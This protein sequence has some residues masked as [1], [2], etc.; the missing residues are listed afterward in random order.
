M[1]T[2][3]TAPNGAGAATRSPRRNAARAG[4]P[5]LSA[6]KTHSAA[7]NLPP[8]PAASTATPAGLNARARH[9][10]AA[11]QPRRERATPIGRTE[12]LAP[13]LAAERNAAGTA[14]GWREAR[15]QAPAEDRKGPRKGLRLTVYRAAGQPDCTLGGVTSMA[16]N[17]TITMIR[18]IGPGLKATEYA[19]PEESQVFTP[20]PD[21]PE[22]VLVIRNRPGRDPWVHLQPAENPGWH[23]MHGG[24]YA[25][26]S[27]SRWGKIS[28][29]DLVAVH[30]RHEG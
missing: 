6:P 14:A 3:T 9:R 16:G 12:D 30:D 1:I 11:R 18:E 26:T 24:N 2:T 10:P 8:Q 19:V 4:E 13:T 20:A 29:A 27:D 22:V 5:A 21:A 25:G 17:V 28:G 7:A 15:G 23:Y